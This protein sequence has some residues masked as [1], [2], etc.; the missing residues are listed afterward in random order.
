MLSCVD[1]VVALPF[2]LVTVSVLDDG[3]NVR[4]PSLFIL[5]PFPPSANIRKRVTSV[6]DSVSTLYRLDELITTQ[7]GS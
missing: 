6:D 4:P 2:R 7:C 5:L 1:A 3:L